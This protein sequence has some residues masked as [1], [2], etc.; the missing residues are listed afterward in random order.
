MHLGENIKHR[1]IQSF[2]DSYLLSYVAVE[3]YEMTSNCTCC[4]QFIKV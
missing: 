1:Y 3:I 2:A 4:M